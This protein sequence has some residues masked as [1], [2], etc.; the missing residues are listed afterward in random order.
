M[1]FRQLLSE[2]AVAAIIGRFTKP[3]Y[4]ARVLAPHRRDAQQE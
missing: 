4:W 3:V 1:Y 2:P